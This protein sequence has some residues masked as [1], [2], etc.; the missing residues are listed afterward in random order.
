[1]AKGDREK[2]QR[3]PYRM[4]RVPLEVYEEVQRA[5][6]EEDRSAAQ[7]VK[8]LLLQALLARKQPPNTST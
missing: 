4:V 3:Q 8:R 5:A 1:M 2:E 7:M 6:E